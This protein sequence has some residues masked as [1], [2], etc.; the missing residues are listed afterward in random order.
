MATK[1][2]Q[3]LSRMKPP[4][5]VCGATLSL[6]GYKAFVFDAPA[7]RDALYRAGIRHNHPDFEEAMGVLE[8]RADALTR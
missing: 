4:V 3:V 5:A 1:T 6:Y 2:Q 8:D 7:A